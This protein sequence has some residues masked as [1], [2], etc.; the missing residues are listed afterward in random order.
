M[1][2]KILIMYMLQDVEEALLH[3]IDRTKDIKVADDF[4]LTPHGV[5]MLDVSAIRLM[6]VGEEINKI[7]KKTKGE[8]LKKYPEIEWGKIIAFRNFIAHTYFQVNAN[9]LFNVVKND[10]KPLLQTIQKIIVDLRG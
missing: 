8:L 3:V 5:D 10:V 7:D 2:D 9:V 4:A 6:A 1:Y